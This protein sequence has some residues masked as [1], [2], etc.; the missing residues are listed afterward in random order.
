MK[1]FRERSAFAILDEVRYYFEILGRS[2]FYSFAIVK[3]KRLVIGRRYLMV[4]VVIANLLPFQK[5]RLHTEEATT[6]R[7]VLY[8]CSIQLEI[9]YLRNKGGLS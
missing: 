2:A 8:I 5:V 1:L 6:Y 9:E 7:K 4:D 3:G